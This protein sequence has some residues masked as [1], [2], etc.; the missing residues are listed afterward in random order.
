MSRDILLTKFG[1]LLLV[2]VLPFIAFIVVSMLN[3]QH[4]A[5]QLKSKQTHLKA[6][7]FLNDLMVDAEVLR[8]ISL[9]ASFGDDVAI[10]QRYTSLHA[11]LT[12]ALIDFRRD[13]P[14][15]REVYFLDAGVT[16]II[17]SL[18]E[19][20]ASAGLENW[21]GA[22]D[23][24]FADHQRMIDVIA[25]LQVRL[26]AHA[27]MFTDQDQLTAQL[28]YLVLEEMNDVYRAI[29]Q[30]RGFGSYVLM[31]GYITSQNSEI[32]D[33]VYD[34][35]LIM[36]ERLSAQAQNVLR[37]E[38][39]PRLELLIT[40]ARF[41]SLKQLAELLSEEVLQKP[42]LS[43]DWMP[44]FSQASDHLNTLHVIKTD[45]LLY[46]STR[47]KARRSDIRQR[48]WLA[49][50]G[51]LLL[52][53][54]AGF[55][56]AVDIREARER[57]KAL[58]EKQSIEATDAARSKFLAT[59]S[60]EV[61]TP[62][63]GVMGMANLLANTPL[64]D[65]QKRYL[66]AIQNSGK[67]LLGVINDILDYSR[68]EA[69]KM[70]LEHIRF[71]LPSLI[72]ECLALFQFQVVGKDLAL[73]MHIDAD[74]PCEVVSDPT[75]V[76]QVLLNM[77]SNALKFTESG[78]IQ[79][80][81]A[82]LPSVNPAR[83]RVSVRDTGI[84]IDEEKMATMFSAFEQADS[85]ITRKYGGTG[86]GLAISKQLV[87]LMKGDIGAT[88]ELGEGAEFWFE[89]ALD[90]SIDT[91]FSRWLK[92]D[93]L[94]P[95]TLLLLN[96]E[97]YRA[98]WQDL[99]TCWGFP[100]QAFE[101]RSGFRQRCEIMQQQDCTTPLIIVDQH[102]LNWIG[103]LPGHWS[104][105]VLGYGDVDMNDTP[106]SW[107]CYRLSSPLSI[108][109]LKNLLELALRQEAERKTQ[110]KR[111]KFD[112]KQSQILVAEDNSINQ[113]VI[114]GILKRMNASVTL[115]ENGK[116]ALDAFTQSPDHYAAILMDW[117]MPEMDGVS[118]CREIRRWERSVERSPIPIIALTAHALEHYEKEAYKAG[119]QDF[120]TKPV[121]I[122]RLGKSLAQQLHI[123][124]DTTAQPVQIT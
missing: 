62:I 6:I 117:E 2:L 54:V 119:M 100:C 90:E 79:V 25:K 3:D 17:N 94:R 67:T 78:S 51:I 91:P 32:L 109:Q 42:E 52:V 45:A 92:P 55:V 18:R 57:A 33:R 89:F 87:E 97:R 40:P 29:G 27:G 44:L 43:S 1:L 14:L 81:V 39:N 65:E 76:R 10:N 12:D 49:G 111:P 35:L 85:S 108:L 13:D 72:D 107:R 68:I 73:M 38:Q 77:L 106:A 80:K 34:N 66:L 60:H 24:L 36:P 63:N 50:L 118:A 59:M 11:S 122:D 48:Q 123:E 124:V 21:A 75:R 74:V 102:S 88:G 58:R 105:I 120:L 113:M 4:E 82:F 93:V 23:I 115:V 103:K 7:R 22:Q 71:D 70:E 8:D 37:A 83:V 96:N 56:Y 69:G 104:P 16:N 9:I 53:L 20:D 31:R 101:T 84:G 116:L 98:E 5:H 86:L 46:V 114:K 112:L 30:L 61:R 110:R 99:L 19:L 26:A 64:D 41:V 28:L 47:Y 95:P 121:D 15:M